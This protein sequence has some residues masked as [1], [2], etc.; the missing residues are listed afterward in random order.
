MNQTNISKEELEKAYDSRIPSEIRDK[1]R[2]ARVAIA[3]IGGLGSNIAVMLA[4]S[5]VGHIFF[6]D[7]DVVDA[8]NLNRQMYFASQIGMPKTEA[9]SD[10]LY[11]INPY[12]DYSCKQVLVTEDN[13]KELFKDYKYIAEAFDR[14]DQKA[15]L[16]SSLLSLCPDSYVVSGNGMAGFENINSIHTTKRLSKLYVCGDGSSDVSN[17]PGLW[18]PRVTACAAHQANAIINLILGREVS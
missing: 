3:G 15:M 11:R 6:V 8:T 10:I 13:V 4:R 14:P 16:V 9:L 2:N 5:G 7:F 1:I 12:G 18:S 17:K